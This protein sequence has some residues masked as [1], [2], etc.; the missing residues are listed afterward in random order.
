MY[1][2]DNLSLCPS[3]LLSL[4]SL[5][6]AF[7][8]RVVEG[9]GQTECGGACSVTDPA[10]Q[11]SLGHVGGPLPSNELKLVSVPDLG[12]NVTDTIHGREVDKATGAVTKEGIA[13][14]G[15][16]EIC[17]RGPNVFAG[18]LHALLFVSL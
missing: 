9:Y 4:C 12:Y 2:A 17:I 3:D 5:R 6:I 11:A 10:D 1:L 13:C 15:R 18:A 7:S 14:F 8:C 16:G